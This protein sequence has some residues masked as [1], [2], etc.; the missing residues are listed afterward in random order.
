MNFFS[1][2]TWLAWS[3]VAV[4]QQRP[5][6]VQLQGPGTPLRAARHAER[7]V[8]ACHMAVPA[9][10]DHAEHAAP[11]P[12]AGGPGH[13]CGCLQCSGVMGMHQDFRLAGSNPIKTSLTLQSHIS[14]RGLDPYPVSR[15]RAAQ[16][17]PRGTLR[18]GT[19]KAGSGE[20]NSG[21]TGFSIWGVIMEPLAC[22][23]CHNR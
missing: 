22:C 11:S 19:A 6:G 3:L 7:R 16:W 23:Q 14:S 2:G 21:Q 12:S 4:L 13:S 5:A 15:T 1:S 18:I 17:P 10:A 20:L 8:S 9:R